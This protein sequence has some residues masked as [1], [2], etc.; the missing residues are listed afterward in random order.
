MNIKQRLLIGFIALFLLACLISLVACGKPEEEPAN[1]EVVVDYQQTVVAHQDLLLKHQ[2]LEELYEKLR[3]REAEY[4]T[5]VSTL[6]NEKHA[7]RTELVI[8]QGLYEQFLGEHNTLL[9]ELVELRQTRGG[10]W[11]VLQEEY[12]KA[13]ARLQ[14][15]EALFPPKDFPSKDT[16]VEWRANSGNITELGCLGLQ[17]LALADGYIVS[18][19]LG[20]EYCTVI[21]SGYWYRITPSD[22]ELV[23]KIGKVE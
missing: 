2:E 20:S 21:A 12:D 15:L 1:K 22:K 17:R 9:V 16:L 11:D 6:E 10:D 14:R 23:E 5:A 19:H 4:I 13:L 8:T 18:V 3:A 7:L